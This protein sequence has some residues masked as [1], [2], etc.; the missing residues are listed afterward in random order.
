MFFKFAKK[1]Y[2]MYWAQD[3]VEFGISNNA[4]SYKPKTS[5][6]IGSSF[7]KK[8]LVVLLIFVVITF[9]AIII[10][11]ASVQLLKPQS[12]LALAERNRQRIITIPS[13]R[14]HIYDSNG[15]VLTNNVPNFLLAIRPQDLPRDKI[16]RDRIII[17]LSEITKLPDY[18]VANIL[19]EYGSYSYESIVI[20]E[21]LD[22]ETALSVQID[23]VGLPG[24]EILRSSKRLYLHNQESTKLNTSTMSLSH[25][26]G[27]MGKLSPSEL[28]VFY[29][30]G[31]LPS[32]R[33]GKIGLEKTY[34]SIVRGTYGSKKIEVDARGQQQSILSEIPPI[35]GRHIELALDQNIQTALTDALSSVMVD[36][37]KTKGVA[38]AM[39]PNNGN[40]LAMVSLPSFDNND[41]SGG[42]DLETYESY[43]SNEDR[44]LFNRA[45]AGTYPSGSSIKPAIGASALQEGLITP[46][47]SF[48]STG[49]IAVNIWFFPD[50]QAGG[51]G[52][53][54]LRKALAWSVNTF[55]YYVGGGH[56]DFT[57]LGVKKI[58]SYLQQFGF[59]DVLG[60]DI[61]GEKPG[62]LPSKDWKKE[63]KNE[64]WYIGDTY[65]MSIGQGDV[66]VTPLQIAA[67]T[68]VIANNGTLYQPRIVRATIDAISKEKDLIKPIVIRQGF[69]GSN[70]L[71]TVRLGM[72][73]CVTYGS[74]QR[75][76]S[77]P[78]DIAGKTGT[79]QWSS[80]HKPHAWFTSFAPYN[81]PE[82]VVTVLVE[83]GEGG[84]SGALP[85]AEKFYRWWASYRII[86]L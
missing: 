5:R 69:I 66:L 14:G 19:N 25:L 43:I 51:H 21:D 86:N 53:T 1:K 20:K 84:S 42:I 78:L 8:G 80:K 81:N 75:L 22:Y 11:L 29:K 40:V 74:C 71:D 33:I 52:I 41:F 28:R 65:N 67:M 54:N 2:K 24:I 30:L 34:E 36:N 47:T 82:I 35:P 73:D 79:A 85:V 64:S 16:E 72:R 45:V 61:P 62:F 32:D 50:W 58:A 83:E 17:R 57:G 55:F 15:T 3:M 77:Q 12:F 26:V 60:I 39:D 4:Y 68:A 9:V 6:H 48:N 70:N 59:A 56:N 18:Q 10:R 38:I 23:A 44:P 37:N 49:G 7:N 13:E 76:A 63:V 31:Y 46:K 27:Y